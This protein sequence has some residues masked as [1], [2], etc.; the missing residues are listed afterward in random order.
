MGWRPRRADVP[1]QVQRLSPVEL[2]RAD[3]TGEVPT[4]SAGE[5]SLA[6]ERPV[7]LFYSGEE[8]IG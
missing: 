8:L 7:F 2:G 6:G 3:I 4:Q 1:V 5:F